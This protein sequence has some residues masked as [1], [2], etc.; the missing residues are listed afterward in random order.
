MKLYSIETGNFK[1]DGGA[2][3]G[4]VP[5]QIWNKINPA[6]D[7]NLCSWAMRCLL[8]ED[9]DRLILIDNG[10]GNKQDE[11]FFGHYHLHGNATLDGSLAAHGFHR[12]DIT[13]VFLTHLH[14]DHCGGSIIR[15]GDTLVP[16]FSK[17]TYWS[18]E[19]HWEWAVSPND[20]EKASFLK[21]NIIPIQQ[22]GQLKF[23][24]QPHHQ[25]IDRLP[26][27]DFSENFQVRFT[28][29]H[30]ESMML[31]Q[32]T[33]KD[34][35]IVFMADLLPSAGHIPIPYVMAYDMFP[36]TTLG[37]KK[38]FLTEAAENQ[39]ILFFEHD[40]QRECCELELTEKGVRM[41]RGFALAEL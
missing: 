2:M 10:I 12:D 3:F 6:D 36:L 4:V 22:S 35:T 25:D 40:A 5:K 34:R 9:G 23:V 31:P 18:N 33:Y 13:D 16:A 15:Q 30:T 19:K 29:G 8:V 21:E 27:A 7:N 26:L 17:A 41:G 1:L 39:F 38:R 32:L 20:R 11:K 24:A 37:E 28:C 14:F